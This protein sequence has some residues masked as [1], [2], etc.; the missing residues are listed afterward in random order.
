MEMKPPS[1]TKWLPP[2]FR[3]H[4][5]DE[6]LITYYLVRKIG[7]DNFIDDTI[8]EVDLNAHEPWELS[9]KAQ[10]MGD[11]E[12]YFFS[13][14]DKKYPMGC[15]T[16]RATKAGYW[17]ATG[18]DKEVFL[19]HTR[20]THLLK[21]HGDP[22]GMKKTLVF[23]EGRAPKGLKSNW[24]MH[25]YRLHDQCACISS[26]TYN[27][28]ADS[29]TSCTKDDTWVLCRVFY[30]KRLQHLTRNVQH[31]PQLPSTKKV[32][33]FV[34]GCV[35]NDTN[36]LQVSTHNKVAKNDI[37]HCNSLP[38]LCNGHMDAIVGEDDISK[39]LG[40]L[41]PITNLAAM[42]LTLPITPAPTSSQQTNFTYDSEQFNI[43]L[44]EELDTIVKSIPYVALPHFPSELESLWLQTSS[45]FV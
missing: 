1:T 19:K 20:C 6:E 8:T 24:V 12:W 36:S 32:Y 33:S 25:E 28:Q 42:P 27:S 2:G 5:T 7:D 41:A 26:S 44:N 10:M 21:K 22:I 29:K 13:L 17:K 43:M 38:P 37:I 30:K 23:Y 11:R 16:N 14:K 4:P 18:K 39:S 31:S 34:G 15:R 9:G 35:S 3:F 45:F 40:L